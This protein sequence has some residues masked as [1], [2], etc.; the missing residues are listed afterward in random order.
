MRRIAFLAAAIAFSLFV[1]TA[2]QAA[3]L[4]SLL[5]K[6]HA[7]LLFAKSRSDAAL[8]KQIGLFSERRPELDE[9]DMV[10]IMTT[11]NRDAMAVIG[12]A[13]IAPGAGRRLLRE[14]APPES[15]LTVILVSKGGVELMR[16]SGVVAPQVIFDAI[17]AL[18]DKDEEPKSH[19]GG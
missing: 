14:F 1:V 13:S 6:K 15:G 8:D 18:P 12:Y 4:D 9:R 19:V 2:A 5:G 11:M 7:V 3:A 16:W 17:D 10:V